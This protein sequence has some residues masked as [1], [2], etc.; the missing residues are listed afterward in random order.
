VT[1]KYRITEKGQEL[2]HLLSG[3]SDGEYPIK[4]YQVYTK[5]SR[6]KTQ[7]IINILKDLNIIEE[8]SK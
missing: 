3:I 7:K 6:V 2:N 5:K 8:V 1:N 4:I